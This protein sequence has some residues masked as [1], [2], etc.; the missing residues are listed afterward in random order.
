MNRKVDGFM[1]WEARIL[2]LVLAL[3]CCAICPASG[4]EKAPKASKGT[5][6]ETADQFFSDQKIRVFQFE[7]PEAGLA[8]LRRSPRTNVTGTVREGNHVL[9]NVAIHLKGMGSFRVI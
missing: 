3:A 6:K 5:K 1:P 9:T 2:F 4:A 8:S 7:V